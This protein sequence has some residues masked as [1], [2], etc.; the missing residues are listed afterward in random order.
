[1]RELSG[2][3]EGRCHVTSVSDQLTGALYRVGL[4]DRRGASSLVSLAAR[5]A[6]ITVGE[7]AA[8]LADLVSARAARREPA[9][10]RS[11]MGPSSV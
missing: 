9:R 1:M 3:S 10:P 8:S 11:E 5:P 6:R 4:R 2:M 7:V